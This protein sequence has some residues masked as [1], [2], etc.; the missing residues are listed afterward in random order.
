VQTLPS[1]TTQL[2]G[3]S[4]TGPL[5]SAAVKSRAPRFPTHQPQMFRRHA[6]KW[7][8]QKATRLATAS[9]VKAAFVVLAMPVLALLLLRFLRDD[10]LDSAR[11]S[12]AAVTPHERLVSRI[13]GTPFER[14][15]QCAAS[16]RDVPQ[17]SFLSLC[18]LLVGSATLATMTI[19]LVSVFAEPLEK[20]L[21]KHVLC[22]NVARALFN[23]IVVRSAE[24]RVL[25]GMA[26]FVG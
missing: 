26:V 9:H 17:E 1:D 8:W 6:A 12:F 10:V 20:A 24:A 11:A 23:S 5:I 2:T 21:L 22:G 25:A 16:V 19:V 4:A 3:H 7:P 18:V 13:A 14:G 15:A